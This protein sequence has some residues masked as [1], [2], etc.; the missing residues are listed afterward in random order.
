MTFDQ[1]KDRLRWIF[2]RRRAESDLEEEIRAHLAIEERERT[3]AGESPADARLAARRDF[4]N[5]LLVKETTRDVWSV[6]WV[7]DLFRDL[8]YG[9]RVL[10]RNPGFATVAILTLALGIGCNAAMFSVINSVLL[11]PLP[12]RD[13]D[14][15]VY[16][17]ESQPADG[18]Q[19]M[20]LNGQ[21]YLD[22]KAQNHTL[23]DATL[24]GSPQNF[25]ASGAG[26]TETVRVAAMEANFLSV[27]GVQPLRGRGFVAGEDMPDKNKVVILGYGF[28]Q[29]HYA[30][31]AGAI[32]ATL[33]LDD[34]P[35]SVVGVLP[36]W[37][38]LPQRTQLWVPL[39]MK[40][41]HEETRGNHSYRA[42]GRLKSGTRLA[43]ARADLDAI[44]ARLAA[45][46]PDT[47]HGETSWLQPLKERI[48]GDSRQQLLVL[49]A[50]VAL[51]LLVAC[52][53]V[54]NLLLARAT[55]RQREMALRAAL[56]AR[57]LRL[58]RQMLTESVLL[59]LLGAIL[60]V[61]LAQM[62]VSAIRKS[63]TLPIPQQAPIQLDWRV[64]VFAGT[65]SIIV[66]LLFG[67][68]PVLQIS[69]QRLAHDLKAAVQS[70]SSSGWRNKLRDALVTVEIA[71]SLALLM[72]AGLLL[73]SFVHL[74]SADIGIARQNVTT[75][76]LVLP[77]T[78]YKGVMTRHNTYQQLLDK[79]RSEPGAESAAIS[80]VLPLEGSRGRTV[81]VAEGPA[82]KHAIEWNVVT[83]DYF[84][85]MGIPLLAG[86][87][88]N[89]S[90]LAMTAKNEAR[91]E[92]IRERNQDSTEGDTYPVVIN[93]ALANLLFHGHG[94][95]GKRLKMGTDVGEIIGIVGDVKQE[96][97]R[98][99]AQ[100]EAY[101]PLTAEI[102]N[103]WYP[104][105]IS[106]RSSTPASSV[107]GA[108]R[109]DLAQLNNNLSF[110]NVR[111]MEEVIADNMQDT[112][113][114]TALL[115][116]FAGIALLL[117]GI[118]LYGV[119]AYAVA[120]RTREIGIRMALGAEPRSVLRMIM[121]RGGLLTV[122]GVAL[123]APAAFGLAR[124]MRS[125]L[126]GVGAGDPVT[127]AAVALLLS[128]VAMMACYIPARRA[129]R[130]DAITA[131]RYE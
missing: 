43:E 16:M 64:L 77:K 55:G 94:A 38:N 101:G 121:G 86:R 65:V 33:L 103:H 111:S 7:E 41:Q 60:G 113:L 61:L 92:P 76:A 35:Y 51:V 85:V 108:A 10:R 100:P 48:T 54:A 52:A 102:S 53:N 29:T 57:R 40:A 119:M 106:I 5:P 127:F 44:S 68:A 9:L 69:V 122:A 75:L 50:A 99:D 22:W 117:A 79:I 8:L 120:Q 59:S 31:G 2:R 130:V 62:C 128:L 19:V 91:L 88:F 67:M 49:M 11:R 81:E 27:L 115:G 18:Y 125:L 72:G 95:V 83:E 58:V 45:Q 89:A 12:F 21:D 82:G 14:R 6:R 129:M 34:Q 46:Y 96:S 47:N 32:G 56:G 20:A 78:S 109:H 74:R 28:W 131:L 25:N 97:I 1:W 118:G 37:F 3:E 13:S 80:L 39:D 107:A 63:P 71:L 123:G 105:Q 98:Q 30:G 23:E 73:R 26:E 42:I 70:V 114:Q 116:T 87:T 66:G 84:R 24:F 112:S 126:F 17:L 36:P 15:L 124:W 93:Q 4:G 90:D 110:F 104:A